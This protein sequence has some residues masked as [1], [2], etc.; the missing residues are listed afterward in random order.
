VT[1][2]KEKVMASLN[3]KDYMTETPN[4]IEPG[5][6]IAHAKEK[7]RTLQCRHLPVL[8]GGKLVGIISERDIM[9]VVN[10][11][12]EDLDHIPVGDVMLSEIFTVEKEASVREVVNVMIKNRIGSVLITDDGKLEGIFTERDALNVLDKIAA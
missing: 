8:S 1:Q 4:S 9:A 10:F 2:S 7:M 11:T 12:T 5:Q 6:S 3:I